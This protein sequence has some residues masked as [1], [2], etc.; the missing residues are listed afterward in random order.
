MHAKG[1]QNS[2]EVVEELLALGVDAGAVAGG[3]GDVVNGDGDGAV[4]GVV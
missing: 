3:D 4:V 1:V 2:V